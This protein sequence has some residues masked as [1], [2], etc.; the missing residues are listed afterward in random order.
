MQAQQTHKPIA[1][2]DAKPNQTNKAELLDVIADLR[3]IIQ[4]TI[5]AIS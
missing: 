3:G 1:V 2:I 4:D 5:K